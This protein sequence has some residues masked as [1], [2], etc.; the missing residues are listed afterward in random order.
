MKRKILFFTVIILIIAITLFFGFRYT[1]LASKYIPP[2]E[3][4]SIDVYFCPRDNCEDVYNK[5]IRESEDIKCALYEI[6]PIIDLFNEKSKE[7]DVKIVVDNSNKLDLKNFDFIRFDNN[8]QL[9]HNKFCLLKIKDKN[10]IFTGSLNPTEKGFNNHNN[11]LV[12]I[13]SNYLYENYEGEF[14]ELWSNIYGK[15]DKVK[16][17]IINFNDFLIENYFCPEDLC[18]QK[19]LDIINNA[20]NS[21]YFMTFSFTSDNIGDLIIKK[22]SE[23]I[24]VK[25]IFDKLQND[26]FSEFFKMKNKN[27]NVKIYNG[28]L[29]H[30]KVFIVDDTVVFGSYNPTKSGDERND[31]NIIIIHNKHVKDEFLKEFNLLF[32]NRK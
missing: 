32:E 2:S 25:G 29:M 21:I 27:L 15:G 10:V 18:E 12:V 20:E 22:S 17:P 4:G 7:I 31:E 13:N 8:N 6:G 19:V 5:L 23:K 30:H 24:E 11:N 9:M 14:N 28:E 3:I 26:E 1:G 16:Y